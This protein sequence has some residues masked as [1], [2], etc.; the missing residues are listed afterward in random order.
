MENITRIE[1]R[2]ITELFA[3]Y[4]I[5]IGNEL[6][7]RSPHTIQKILGSNPLLGIDVCPHIFQCN[8]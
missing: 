5:N 7:E 1:K 2:K 4:F 8:F 3:E 6:A